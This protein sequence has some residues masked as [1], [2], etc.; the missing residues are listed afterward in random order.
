MAEL[1]CFR[2]GLRIAKSRGFNLVIAESDSESLVQVLT[3]GIRMETYDSTLISDCKSL[4]QAFQVIKIMH[5]LREGNQCAD[6]LAN[7]GQNT[8]WGTTILDHP[9]EG[10]DVL[11]TRDARGV[12]HSRWH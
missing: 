10:L 3:S 8:T 5:V 1:W 2:E 9:P 4:M 6:F 7:L 12:S 11:L